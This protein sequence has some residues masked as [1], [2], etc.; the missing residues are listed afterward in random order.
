MVYRYHRA[1]QRVSERVGDAA[2]DQQCAG[3]PRPRGHCDRVDLA[4]RAPG[5][6]EDPLQ[7]RQHAA[8]VV[9]GREFRHDATVVLM[10]VHLG[11]KRLGQQSGLAVEKRDSG[12]VAG[13]LDA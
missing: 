8:N 12:L 13:G 5:V 9:A 2:A 6:T 7:Q 4:G 11:V 10:H 1:G 3:E